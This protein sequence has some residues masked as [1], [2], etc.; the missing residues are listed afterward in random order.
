MEEELVNSPDTADEEPSRKTSCVVLHPYQN[1]MDRARSDRWRSKTTHGPSQPACRTKKSR[2]FY[3]QF[4]RRFS[5]RT[6]I[7]WI[8]RGVIGGG[9]RLLTGR[10]NLLVGQKKAVSSTVSSAV[11]SHQFLGDISGIH[12]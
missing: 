4:C 11:S 8:V 12:S 2:Q 10:A 9:R 7:G 1:W 6:K 3:R 5:L